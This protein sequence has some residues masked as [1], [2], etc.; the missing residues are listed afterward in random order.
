MNNAPTTIGLI[1][2]GGQADETE[3][4]LRENKQAIAFRA[5]DAR[6]VPEGDSRIIAIETASDKA[7]NT[8]VIAAIGAPALRA[9]MVEKWQGSDYASVISRHAVVDLTSN[10]SRGCIVAPGAIITTNISVG[11]HSIINTGVTIGHDCTLGKFTTISPGVHFGGKVT[12]GDGVFVGIGAIIK[13][14][15]SIASGVVIGA[16]AVVL[17]DIEE[18]NSVYVGVPARKITVNEGWLH[19]I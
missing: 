11:E 10:I 9:Q 14:G 13:N 6:Y 12:L 17:H 3:A 8:P 18:Q 7:L 4:Y 2:S 1:G 16:G 5:V 15:V 19:E